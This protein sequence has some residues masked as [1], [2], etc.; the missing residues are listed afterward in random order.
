M[1]YDR[2]VARLITPLTFLMVYPML[3][4]LDLK[5]RAA[6]ADGRLQI[7]TQL[8]NFGVIPFLGFALGRLLFPDQPLI[9]VGLLL[10]ALLPT[11]GMTLS[12]TGFARGSVVA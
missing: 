6:R 7:V 10:T 2:A 8:L 5:Q 11:S 12:W 4:I 1:G 3:A 9:V